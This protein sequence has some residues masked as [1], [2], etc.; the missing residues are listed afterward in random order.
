MAAPSAIDASPLCARWVFEWLTGAHRDEIAV[1]PTLGG[2]LANNPLA[3]VPGLP[4]IW[5]PH[6]RVGCRGIHAAAA[7]RS[8]CMT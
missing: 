4:I 1:I 8:R 7:L 3:D 5:I 6:S 2:W